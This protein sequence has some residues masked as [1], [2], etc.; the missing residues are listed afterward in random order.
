MLFDRDSVEL[1]P[2]AFLLFMRRSFRAHDGAIATSDRQRLLV[3]SYLLP[4]APVRTG[5][6]RSVCSR[7]PYSQILYDACSTKPLQGMPF[8]KFRDFVM[9]ADP[10]IDYSKDPRSVLEQVDSKKVYLWTEKVLRGTVEVPPVKSYLE[11]AK[12]NVSDHVSG[13]ERKSS[14]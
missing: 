11:A 2:S 5:K 10:T 13:R 6:A 9:N 4:P 7:Y 14:E 1:T 8:R 12:G 3:P